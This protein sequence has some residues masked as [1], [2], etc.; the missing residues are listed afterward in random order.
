MSAFAGAGPS[1]R[2]LTEQ[3]IATPGDARYLKLAG[4]QV[5]TAAQQA[6]LRAELGVLKKN[7][8]VNGGMMVSQENGS[9][10]GTVASYYPVD[11]FF[12][13]VAVTSAAY[14]IAQVASKTPGG[15]LNRVRLTVTSADAAVGSTDAAFIIHRIEGL[16]VADLNLGQATAKTVTLQFGVKAPAGTYCIGL[17]NGSAN[18]AYVAEYVISAA[19][20]NTDVVKSV[21]LG[22]DQAGVWASDNTL[23]LE[24]VFTLMAGSSYQQVAGSWQATGNFGTA[25]QFNFMSTNGNV[26]ELFDVG[27]YE[28]S[29]APAFQLPDFADELALCQRYYE[30]SD[31]AAYMAPS[32]GGYSGFQFKVTKRTTPTM[33]ITPN[34][35]TVSGVQAGLWGCYA[36]FSIGPTSGF[37]IANAR[38]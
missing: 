38:M 16:R 26:F 11:Q 24:I 17:R 31:S 7:Y 10:A 25:N 20:A 2:A 32:S 14:S 12:M 4:G 13:S 29:V 5:L 1:S 35:G 34:T 22:L 3:E 18:R 6:A 33:T 23:G 36:Q 27:L 19:E 30:K 8:I 9:A 28:G 37:Y 21:T 15:S